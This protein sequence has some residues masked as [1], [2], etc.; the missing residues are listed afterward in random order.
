MLIGR[1]H[2][3]LSDLPI[4]LG[5]PLPR[6]SVRRGAVWWARCLAAAA[7]LAAGSAGVW[8]DEASLARGAREDSTPQQR[9]QTAL[10]EAGGGLK[11]G[12]AECRNLSAAERRGCE[13]EAR[14]RYRE[15]M[16]RARELLRNPQAR[17]VNIVG[18]PIRVQE[19]TIPASR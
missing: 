6:G 12:L 18:E 9:Y 17:P 16:A 2:W 8:A 19:T 15:D 14:E 13:A 7:A 10:R 11:V 5:M 4:P 3:V 1:T